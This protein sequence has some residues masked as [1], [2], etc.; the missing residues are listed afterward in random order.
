MT[1]GESHN[2]WYQYYCSNICPF[3][4]GQKYCRMLLLN[5]GQKYCRMLQGILQY[6]RPSLSYQLLLRS[7]FCLFLSRRFT[8]VLLYT[9][10]G[11]GFCVWSWFCGIV[12]CILYGLAIISL[13]KRDLVTLLNCL[14][15][16]ACSSWCHGFAC[17]APVTHT[18]TDS[19]GKFRIKP[20]SSAEK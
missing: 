5:A 3:K 14:C 8:Q 18:L 20:Q 6:F 19:Y 11:G 16:D 13:R 9:N 4:A 1:P 10:C 15:S 7:L 17:N 2:E 12:H